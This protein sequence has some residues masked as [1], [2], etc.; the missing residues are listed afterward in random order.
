MVHTL[1]FSPASFFT[2]NYTFIPAR[3]NSGL[4]NKLILNLEGG[5]PQVWVVNGMILE[6]GLCLL[7][8]HR[9]VNDDVFTL[10]P[11]HGGGN[12]MLVTNL[13]S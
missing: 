7:V 6:E 3:K 4:H 8:A 9:R 1:S 5:G 2:K 13:E 12:T 10:L 11:V